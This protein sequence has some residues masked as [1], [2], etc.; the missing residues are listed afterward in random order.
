MITIENLD[1]ARWNRPAWG[2]D[3]SDANAWRSTGY[4][5]DEVYDFIVVEN[6]DSQT[7]TCEVVG[8]RDGTTQ[9]LHFK[10]S[11]PS[12][13]AAADLAEDV[14]KALVKAKVEWDG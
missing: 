3:D 7:A 10:S 11:A 4:F 14:M 12:W 9:F 8:R 1:G 6:P 5:R 13:D 2:R